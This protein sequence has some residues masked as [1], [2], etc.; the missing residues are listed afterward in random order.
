MNSD[1]LNP[2][3]LKKF[4]PFETLDPHQLLLLRSHVR[5]QQYPKGQSIFNSGDID[6]TEYFL[7]R[8]EIELQSPDGIRHRLTESHPTATRQLARLRPRQYTA[9]TMTACELIVVDA[10]VIERI[11][12]DLEDP[13]LA[14]DSY[15]VSEVSSLDELESQELLLGFREALQSNQFVLPSLP[16]IALRVRQLLDHDDSDAKVISNAV[17]ADPSIAAKLIRAANSPMYLGTRACETTRDAVVRLGLATTRQLVVSFAMRDLF[18][19]KSKLLKQLMLKT[20]Q[21]SVEVAAISYVI[22]R[23]SRGSGLSPE[24]AMLAGLVH[25][26]G[27]IAILTYVETKPD[28]IESADHLNVLL[29]NL[30]GEA[31]EE[32]LQRWKFPQDLIDAAKGA[33]QWD[34]QHN[35]SADYCDIVQI[36]K[37][38]SYIWGKQALPVTR[39]DQLPAFEK[40]SLG[41]VTPELTIRILDEAR[42]QITAVKAVL[43]G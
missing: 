23:M 17:N 22:A 32:I 37:L 39:I 25:D 15:G 18:D 42:E 26:V 38:H 1:D 11:Q 40:L 4:Q 10:D 34:R 20:W 28:L 5:W 8:G 33:T 14:L 27:V 30:R 35:R 2:E 24:E 21:Q 36:A 41:E 12:D 6:S 16:E 43:N 7:L 13:G 29:Q 9:V 19:T 3:S 31:G